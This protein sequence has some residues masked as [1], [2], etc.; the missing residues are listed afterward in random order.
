M[1]GVKWL[2]RYG[3]VLDS[4]VVDADFSPDTLRDEILGT[5]TNSAFPLYMSQSML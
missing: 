3:C 4:A 1:R 2:S 5:D